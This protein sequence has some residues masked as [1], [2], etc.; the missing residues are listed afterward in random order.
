VARVALDHHGGGLERGVGDLSD[1][2]LLVVRLLGGDD[3]AY[4]ESEVDARVRHQVG[5]ELGDV[6]VER[7]VETEGRGEGRDHLGDETVEV[8][9]GRALD[10][11]VAA[12]D[13]VQGLV[14]D[15]TC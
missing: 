9:V 5:L 8:G 13:V 2:E 14:V 6:D 3:G 11:E 10:V 1:G 4:E 12:A 15:M 7:T